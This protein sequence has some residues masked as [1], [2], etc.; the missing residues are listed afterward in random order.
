VVAEVLLYWWPEYYYTGGIKGLNPTDQYCISK[1][2]I[3]FWGRIYF[4]ES[5]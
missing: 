4:T 2:I 3:P 1:T 5:F